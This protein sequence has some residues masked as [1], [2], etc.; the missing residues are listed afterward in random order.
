[1]VN[2]NHIEDA[3][4]FGIPNYIYTLVIY[5]TNCGTKLRVEIGSPN[6]IQNLCTECLQEKV[7]SKEG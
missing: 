2:P 1:M 7:Q 4:K 5:C 3:E 6:Y